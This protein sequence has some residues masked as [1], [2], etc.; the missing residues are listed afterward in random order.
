[1]S[2]QKNFNIEKF[3]NPYFRLTKNQVSRKNFN[4]KNQISTKGIKVNRVPEIK[5]KSEQKIKIENK[6]LAK[7]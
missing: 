4:I 1:M 2:E 6:N 5:L 3:V 7:I